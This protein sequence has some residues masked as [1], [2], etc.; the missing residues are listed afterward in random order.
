MKT[1][2]TGISGFVG[3]HLTKE[4]ISS[5]HKVYGIDMIELPDIYDC[6]YKDIIFTKSDILDENKIRQIILEYKPDWIFHLAAISSVL[7][8]W[9][10]KKNTL[11]TNI[12]GT[13]NILESCTL[14]KNKPHILLIGSAEEYGKI[15]LKKP[16]NENTPLNG[17][18]PY[19]ISKITQE[20]LG[21]HY[22]IT[23]HLPIYRTRSFNHT[24][25]GQNESFVCSSFCKQVAEIELL[26]KEPIIYVGNLSSIR[27]FSDVRDVVKAYILIIEKG[28]P[29]EIYNV[30]SM[31]SYSIKEILNIILSFSTKKIK[32]VV[33][34]NR[35][36][37][38]EIPFLKG[39][40]IK[41][42][43]LKW[44]PQYTLE[45]TLLDTLNYW[46]EKYKQK[47]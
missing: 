16:I 13:Y 35:Y 18:T 36:R 4:L 22:I 31:K 44:K 30:C 42:K 38:V 6:L 39:S 19:A 26:N 43:K 12:L 41:L 3:Y 28:K 14:L 37:K 34:K 15:K 5:G 29:S 45:Q 8:S 24:G 25:P 10:D 32:V 17:F 47:I 2:I 9:K 40:N 1:L 33:D 27:D 46:R 20:Y 11:S 21:N 23:Y 7:K